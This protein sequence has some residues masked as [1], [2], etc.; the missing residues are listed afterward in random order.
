M[1]A[2]WERYP[3]FFV[4]FL[5]NTFPSISMVLKKTASLISIIFHP[6]VVSTCLFILIIYTEPPISKSSHLE[7]FVSF[8]FTSAI[9]SFTVFLLLKHNKIA[10]FNA[11]IRKERVV[12][13]AL[14]TV[15]FFIGFI[16][17]YLIGAKPLVQGTMLCYLI[18]SAIG[19][20]ITN[21]W[22][23]SMHA[24]GLGIPFVILLVNDFKYLFLLVVIIFLVCVSRV[25]LKIHSISQ[26]ITGLGLSILN[27]YLIMKI[28]FL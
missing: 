23:I 28:F 5:V 26:V 15:Y 4:M 18:N 17:L 9:V 22:K 13:L 14:G 2:H 21:K 1:I 11:S 6:M 20:L 27:T 3:T 8:F 24:F 25:V 7:F 19:F 10:D 12:P 16:I